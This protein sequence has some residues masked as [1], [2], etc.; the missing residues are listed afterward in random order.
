MFQIFLRILRCFISLSCI[1][2]L[3]HKSMNSKYRN[4]RMDETFHIG[5][6]SR[7]KHD[8]AQ[9]NIKLNKITRRDKESKSIT[10]K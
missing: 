3:L 7:F 6:N 4:K 10:L 5:K 9:S 1:D 8:K 2:I